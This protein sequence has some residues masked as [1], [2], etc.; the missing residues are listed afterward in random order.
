M[1]PK[2]TQ[3][4]ERERREHTRAPIELR[5]EYTRLNAFFAD[6]TKNISKGGT[7]IKTAQ[8][9]T[10]GTEFVFKLFIPS[11]EEPLSLRGRVVRVVAPGAAERGEDTGMGIRFLY[12]DEAERRLIEGVAER[13]MKDSLGQ[14]VYDQLTKKR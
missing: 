8:P 4:P 13:L 5:V 6:Y 7:F 14:H 12:E 10:P 11:L 2:T 9:L 1:S 3:P